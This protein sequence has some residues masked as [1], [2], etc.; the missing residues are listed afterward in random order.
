[1]T[2]VEVLE[3][4]NITSHGTTVTVS[5]VALQYAVRFLIAV[6]F[7]KSWSVDAPDTFSVTKSVPAK[8]AFQRKLEPV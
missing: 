4:A 5:V 2:T 3:N 7:L 6:P 1:M 8:S